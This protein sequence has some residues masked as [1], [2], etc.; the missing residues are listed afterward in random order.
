MRRLTPILVALLQPAACAAHN[1][2]LE[3]YL[4]S[5][6]DW[7][8][9]T[10]VGTN[11][12]TVN[13]TLDPNGPSHIFI[14][15]NLARVLLAAH[16]I[17]A[18]ERYLREGLDWC[19]SF[20][21]LQ[22][23][24]TTSLGETAGWWDTGYDQVYIADTGTAVVALAVCHELQPDASKAA[25]YALAMQRFAL[26]VQHGCTAVPPVE[27]AKASGQCPPRGTGWIHGEDSSP[28]E[29]RGALG[30]G[31][32]KDELNL[33]PYTISTATFGSCGVVELDDVTRG[34]DP[35]L[36]SVALAAAAWIVQNR[37]KDGRIPYTI[38]PPN[39]SPTTY[40][41][42]S[43]SA[44]SFIDVDLRYPEAIDSLTPLRSTCDWLV[45]NQSADGSWGR[46][47]D[48]PR[49]KLHS[50]FTASGD[51]Q[52]S[53]RALSL[54]QWCSTRLRPADP[55]HGA[56]AQRYVDFLL[57]PE[58]SDAFGVNTL[59][60]PTGFVGLAIADFILPWVTFR[61]VSP[62]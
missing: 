31:W 4:T 45:A 30:D 49:S 28:A 7:I 55:A 25:K 46:F 38:T 62:R 59:S 50:G 20:V 5:I 10:G 8:M 22:H 47:D 51:A 6:A 40:Q 61:S 41:P 16:K 19:D 39:D 2:T 23:P 42:I 34:A 13:H 11:N 36:R 17:N 14:N 48:A 37:T 56:A 9:T 32:Y 54:L 24:I 1:A 53:P 12:I 29:W 52:R 44:E 43:Y 33:A 58:Q 60:L 35:T 15:G 26:F 18:N 57:I 3:H 27:S 21:A